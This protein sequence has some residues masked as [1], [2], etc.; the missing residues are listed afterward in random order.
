MNWLSDNWKILFDGIGGA[1]AV[2]L[3]GYAFK[4]WLKSRQQKS[5]NE[6]NLKGVDSLIVNSPVA[7]GTHN[8]QMVNS[9]IIHNA[10]N[11]HIGSATQA[12]NKEAPAT[13]K[14]A[15]RPNIEFVG[16]QGKTVFVSPLAVDGIYDPK[17]EDERKKAV[18]ALI[19]K[20]ENKVASD[21][22]ILAARNVI[23]KITFHSQDGTRHQSIN[24]GVWLNSPCNSTTLGIGDTQ[25]LVLICAIEGLLVT[26]E[27]RR[28]DGHNFYDGF[29][30]VRDAILD[31]LEIVEI[32]VIDKG[33]QSFLH[34]KFKVWRDG[35]NFCV[36]TL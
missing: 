18:Q 6:A 16:S 29:S 22:T 31:G 27:D 14:V 20:F 12:P 26:F 32:T 30:Y 3:V 35:L 4:Q 7:S 11:V 17:N 33:T 36:A 24:Y 10:H 5:G 8:S 13:A 21:R 15:P 28:S 23:A 2:T 25:E 19:L 1:A 34:C 9:P